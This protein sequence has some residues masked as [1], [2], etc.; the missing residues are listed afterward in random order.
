M[1]RRRVSTRLQQMAT[2][3]SIIRQ[4]EALELSSKKPSESSHSR[5]ASQSKL[6]PKFGA[7][8][9]TK[10]HG[11]SSLRNPVKQPS[12]SQLS[13]DIGRYDGGLEI[14]DEKRGQVVY[15]KAAEELALDSSVSRSISSP[16][17]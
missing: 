5:F 10:L 13:L 6:L 17:Y 4:I 8:G 9:P 14:D 11:P 12:N 2:V 1:N 16:V 3:G 7:P 15:G